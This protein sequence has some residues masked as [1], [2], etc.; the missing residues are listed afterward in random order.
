MFFS[1]EARSDTLLTAF[2]PVKDLLKYYT[3]SLSPSP[4]STENNCFT[5]LNVVKDAASVFPVG[6]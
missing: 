3:K 2:L 4:E 5:G 1:W 6:D